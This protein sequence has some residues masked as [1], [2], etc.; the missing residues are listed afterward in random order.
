MHTESR[1]NLKTPVE[2]WNQMVD[3]FLKKVD[4]VHSYPYHP[5]DWYFYLHEWLIF[6][7]DVGKYTVPYMVWDK[8]NRIR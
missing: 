6:M 5:W 2:I 4:H 3:S 1:F 7:V 8:Y